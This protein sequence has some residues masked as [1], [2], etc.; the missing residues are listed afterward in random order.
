MLKRAVGNLLCLAFCGQFLLAQVTTG[1]ISGRITDSTGAVV[2]AAKVIVLN[3]DTGIPRTIQADSAGHY[4]APLL[5]L[6]SYR[7]T[8]SQ[9]GFQTAVRSGV[10]LTVGREAT[11]NIELTVGTVSQTVEVRGEAPLVDTAKG[12]IGALV[13]S[14]TIGELPLNGRDLAQLITLQTGAV[15]YSHGRSEGGKLLV[16]GGGRPTSN[17]FLMDGIAIETYHEKTPTGL[18]GNFLGSEGVREFR[19]ETNAYSAE[20]GRG[21]GGIFNI[22]TKSGTNALHGSAFEFLRNDNLDA[23]RWEDNK[24]DLEKPEFKRNQY[25]FSLGGPIIRDRTFYFGTYESLRER[26]GESLARPT[27]SPSIRLDPAIDLR[28]KPY[29]KLYPL[30]NG[31]IHADGRTGDY[32]FA[33]S[34]PTDE[35]FIQARMDHQFSESDSFFARYTFLDSEFHKPG[36]A[37]SAPGFPADQTGGAVRNHFVAL[38]HNRIVSPTFLNTLRLGFTRASQTEM[39]N[40]DPPYDPSLYFVPSSGIM[41]V[42]TVAG[43]TT[44][45][46]KSKP[47]EGNWMNSFQLGNN[48]VWTKGRQTIKFGL[49]WNLV[50]GNQNSP[51]RDGGNYIFGSIEDFLYR[52]R[53][54]RFRGTIVEGYKDSRRTIMQNVIGLYLQDDI[55]V[56]P[57]LTWNVGL[58]YEFVTVP[59]ERYG[60][61]GNFRGDLAFIQRATVNDATLGNPYIDNPS[62]RNFAPRTGFAWDV[63]GNG[64]MAL[65]G[66]FG[67]FF[68]QIDQLWMRTGPTRMPPHLV[69]LEASA[70]LPFPN[71]PALCSHENPFNPQNP[72]CGARPAANIIDYNLRTPYVMQYNLNVQREVIPNMVVT[73]GYAGSR[74]IRLGALSNLNQHSA[75]NVN[76]RLVYP[77]S[78]TGL[79]N[80]NFGE[81]LYRHAG[82][83][84]WYNSL[85]LNVTRKYAQGLQLGGSYTFSR[86]LDEVSGLSPASDS[87]VSPGRFLDYYHRFL[88]K[89]LS[90][91]DAR[92]VFSFNSIYELPVGPGKTFG[93][94][95]T[96]AGKWILAGWQLGGIVTMS[97]GFPSSIIVTDRFTSLGQRGDFPDLVPGASNSPTRGT[98]QGCTLFPSRDNR[99]S[100]APLGT[101]DMYFDPCSFAPAPARTMGTVGRNTLI[102]PGRAT[103]DFSI[104]K[105]FDV[106]ETVNL[107]FRFEAFN[108]FNRPN[109]GAPERILF[110]SASRPQ[111]NP[112]RIVNTV[113]TARQLQLG[114]KLTF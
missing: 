102:L 47:G 26:L 51:G 111:V 84:S 70:N 97:T 48:S 4:S 38:E 18:S 114:L 36:E 68:S 57:H 67:L 96:G 49:Q 2:P 76:G 20:F 40:Q 19:V 28:V 33:R 8:A 10:V 1:T 65:R 87:D 25:G 108:F 60:R 3:E 12:G 17:V 74:G 55:R 39:L 34:S 7:I 27:F 53:V 46:I 56:T 31:I 106:T 86:S 9:E 35:H 100:G 73:L 52:V 80:P 29:L 30:P 62:L 24:F 92:H 90:T 82:S 77:T 69:E 15:E 11:V 107:Q 112:G 94:G 50:Q 42:L 101:P 104:S 16:V 103:V 63:F 89:A 79:P 13:E 59:T 88:N 81:I 110:D 95:L 105:N 99:P 5:G 78:L 75:Q 91:F 66:G 6:G 98:F 58:R 83:N 37:F 41:G 64:K 93:G 23:R 113:G 32:L 14:S 72:V 44:V 109:F 71:F 85:Q 22:A 43:V 21:S 45:G 54:Q 61:F